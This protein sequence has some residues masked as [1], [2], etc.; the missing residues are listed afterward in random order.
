MVNNFILDSKGKNK[1][2][3]MKL[4]AQYDRM[5]MIFCN[6]VNAKNKFVT[7]YKDAFESTVLEIQQHKALFVEQEQLTQ[8]EADVLFEILRHKNLWERF[9]IWWREYVGIGISLKPIMSQKQIRDAQNK[10]GQTGA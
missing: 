9:C 2:E 10:Y 8:S 3:V 1:E 7:C 5:W 4:Y 6:G